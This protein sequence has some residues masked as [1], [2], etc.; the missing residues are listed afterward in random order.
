M[1]ELHRPFQMASHVSNY[2]PKQNSPKILNRQPETEIECSKT[3]AQ[4]YR[5]RLGIDS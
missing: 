3:A 1:S 5:Q 2:Y 4:V